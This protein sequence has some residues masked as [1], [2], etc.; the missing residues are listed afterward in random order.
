MEYSIWTILWGILVY[1]IVIRWLEQKGIIP[2]YIRSQGPIHTIHTEKGRKLLEKLAAPKG[3]WRMWGNIGVIVASLMMVA[4]FVLLISSAFMVIQNPAPTALSQPRNVLIIPG[5]NEFLPWKVA[6]E[7]FLGL[8]IGLI[9]HEGGHGIMCRVEKIKVKTMGLALFTILPIGAFVEPDENSRKRASR[10]GQIRM[11]S[12]G[13]ANNFLVAIV[14]FLLLFGPVSGGIVMEEGIAVGGIL[15]GS[16]AE[17]AGIIEG[18]RVVGMEKGEMVEEWEV[19]RGN[20][21]EVLRAIMDREIGIISMSGDGPYKHRGSVIGY[22]NN[23]L[24]EGVEV[25]TI[26]GL[27]E[28]IGTKDVVLVQIGEEEAQLIP[29]GALVSLIEEGPWMEEDET[30]WPP[31]GHI[32]VTDINGVRVI[33]DEGL[34]DFLKES[35][36]GMVVEIKYYEFLESENR[37]GKSEQKVQL[38]KHPNSQSGSGFLGVISSEGI[39]GIEFDDIGIVEY[40]AETYLQILG[41]GDRGMAKNEQVSFGSR[42]M[43]ALQLPVLSATSANFSFNFAGFTADNT[44]FYSVGSS[45]EKMDWVVFKLA[46]ILF[47]T[48]WINFNLGLF[49]CIPTAPL[50][51]G[52]ILRKYVEIVIQK[53]SKKELPQITNFV[54][55]GVSVI[56]VMCLVVAIFGPSIFSG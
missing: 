19:K 7:I 20:S 40:P 52:H 34:T 41:G 56:M 29:M 21:D 31:I 3:L 30:Q 49:N 36:P 13:V 35:A 42:M 17:Q 18:D 14:C 23:L 25:Q 15:P 4:T 47:W 2:K 53:I 1:S 38:G 24:I 16:P 43:I 37:W 8:I 33:D 55:R 22:G 12:G 5:V 48:G 26:S 50:D 46:N 10:T 54:C 39:S 44:N 32:V 11:F 27:K 9:V 28:L 51:G 45:L 6:L